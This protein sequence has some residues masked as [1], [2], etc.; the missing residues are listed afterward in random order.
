MI[1]HVTINIAQKLCCFRVPEKAW[2]LCDV[3]ALIFCLMFPV[4]PIPINK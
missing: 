3:W 4:S 2:D 1:A